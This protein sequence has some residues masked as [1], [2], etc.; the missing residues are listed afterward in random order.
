VAAAVGQFFPGGAGGANGTDGFSAEASVNPW[1]FLLMLEGTVA[2]PVATSRST[3]AELPLAAA[4][5]TFQS[6]AAGFGTACRGE[7]SARGEQW[8]PTWDRWASWPEVEAVFREGRMGVPEGSSSRPSRRALDA[9]RAVRQHGAAR[10][11]R[12]FHRYAYIERNGQ[13]NLAVPVGRMTTDDDPHVALLSDVADWVR[14]FRSA[15]KE[16]GPPSLVRLLSR[17]EGAMWAV[18]QSGTPD[19]WQALVIALGEAE[20]ALV[21]R[22]RLAP[23]N[24][25]R[26]LPRLRAGWWDQLGDSP[27]VGLAAAITGAHHHGRPALRPH[28]VPLDGGRFA[29]SEDRLHRGPDVVWTGRALVDDLVAVLKRRAL[30]AEDGVFPMCPGTSL[31]EAHLAAFLDGRVDD[32]RLSGLIRGMTTAEPREGRRGERADL[33]GPYVVVRLAVWPGPVEGLAPN[34]DRRPLEL[35]AAGRYTAAVEVA[36]ARLGA[37]GLR[38][39]VRSGVGTPSDARRLAAALAFPPSLAAYDAL[40]RT[41]RRTPERPTGDPS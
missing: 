15:V 27:E 37:R 23:E 16:D 28:V 24:H 4:P 26:P 3:N 41:V 12:A 25:L 36:A 38:V 29:Q 7:E 40:E 5:F 30:A 32:R 6:V 20:A 17:L 11:I 35:L 13:A 33:P 14:A 31:S 21:T 1:D 8:F 2:L 18:C 22:P 9:A 10:G 39:K 34:V 19:R